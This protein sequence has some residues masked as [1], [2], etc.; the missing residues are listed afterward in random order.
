MR[1]STAFTILSAAVAPAAASIFGDLRGRGDD[2]KVPGDSPLEYC[3][4]DHPNDVL[5]I[6]SVDLSPNPPLA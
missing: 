1:L 4:A 3:K 6:E 5:T 2:L